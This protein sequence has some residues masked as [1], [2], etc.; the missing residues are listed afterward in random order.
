VI[1]SG[2][3]VV[4]EADVRHHDQT[5]GPQDK[6]R[7]KKEVNC[8]RRSQSDEC[9]FQSNE[10]VHFTANASLSACS[11]SFGVAPFVVQD[12]QDATVRSPVL[13]SK[14]NGLPKVTEKRRSMYRPSPATQP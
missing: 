4:S 14:T 2:K 5:H 3:K 12:A 10:I 6:R 9:I 13:P 11:F 8:K 1:A 7:I